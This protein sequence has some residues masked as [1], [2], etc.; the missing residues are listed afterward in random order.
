MCYTQLR[1]RKR[2]ITAH[3]WLPKQSTRPLD[4]KLFQGPDTAEGKGKDFLWCQNCYN[5]CCSLYLSFQS[6]QVLIQFP[7]LP[8]LFLV[9]L[10]FFL[11][12]QWK[13]TLDISDDAK[14]MKIA[15][16]EKAWRELW[17]GCETERNHVSLEMTTTTKIQP[18]FLT[19][20]TGLAYNPSHSSESSNMVF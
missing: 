16:F 6:L 20:P 9:C 19:E 15:F 11:I 3:R 17:C 13:Q 7:W 18:Y 1:W 8:S 12:F 10:I 4:K 14:N 2:Q 5:L